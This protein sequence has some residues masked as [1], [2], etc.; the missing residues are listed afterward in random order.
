MDAPQNTTDTLAVAALAATVSVLGTIATLGNALP[1]YQL[2]KNAPA[3]IRRLIDDEQAWVAKFSGS[4]VG[5]ERIRYRVKP[6]L[7]GALLGIPRRTVILPRS[8]GYTHRA[9]TKP[10]LLATLSGKPTDVRKK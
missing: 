8:N 7:Q 9:T 4:E 1:R 3:E 2:M 10:G 5:V 6:S